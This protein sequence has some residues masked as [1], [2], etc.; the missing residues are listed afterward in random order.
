MVEYIAEVVVSIGHIIY[1]M[2]GDMV[3]LLI[4][5]ATLGRAHM[6]ANVV[7]F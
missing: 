7:I 3:Y 1:R 2:N 4:T 5:L 6:E